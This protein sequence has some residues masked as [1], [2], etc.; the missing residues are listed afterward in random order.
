[1]DNNVRSFYVSSAEHSK[2]HLNT[3]EIYQE[4]ISVL[5]SPLPLFF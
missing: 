2:S 3:G 4:K 5:E 1:M